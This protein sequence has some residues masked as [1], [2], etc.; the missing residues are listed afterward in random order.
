VNI[1]LVASTAAIKI[2]APKARHPKP[3]ESEARKIPMHI[4]GNM[5]TTRITRATTLRG[6]LRHKTIAMMPEASAAPRISATR[7]ARLSMLEQ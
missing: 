5:S 3:T 2:A 1:D 7:R 6:G 4:T